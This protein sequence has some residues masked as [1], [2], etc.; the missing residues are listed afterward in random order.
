MRRVSA[1]FALALFVGCTS[2]AP[3]VP[4]LKRTIGDQTLAIRV[5]GMESSRAEAPA[6]AP[7]VVPGEYDCI[8]VGG[9]LSG[10]TTAWYLRD[11]KILVLERKDTAGGLSFQGTTPEGIVFGRG[12][13]YYAPPEK[14]SLRVYKDLGLPDLETT[15][16]PEPIDSYWYRGELLRDVWAEESL[17]K[18]PEGFRKF[19][20][21]LEE[22]SKNGRIPV[23]PF[24]SAGDLS[25]DK[26]S[27]AD[28][29]KPF[30]PE[31]RDFLDSYCKSALGAH[32][33]C[34]SAA[35]FCNFY[36]SEITVRHA[37]PGGTGGAGEHLVKKLNAHNPKILRTGATV[38]KVRNVANG[39]EVVYHQNGHNYL[40]RAK[41]AVMA[42]PLNITSWLVEGYPADRMELVKQLKF[43]DYVI[44]TVFTSRELFTA[45]YDTWF[46]KRS[47]TDLIV[48]RWVETHG[49]TK[50]RKPG[51]GILSI[52]QPLAPHRKPPGMKPDDIADLAAGAVKELY[53]MIP[54]LAKE[55]DLRIE[56]YRWP[57]SIHVVP[58]GYFTTWVPKLKAPVVR[59]HFAGSN[60]GTPSF[61]EALY[62]GWAAADEVR[63]LLSF[64]PVRRVEARA[65]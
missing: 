19:K 4:A 50:P 60:L 29:I 27:A 20:E 8:I 61:E 34:L 54:D 56:S 31:V 46:A 57:G 53:D 17:K 24:E 42:T 43:S 7:E 6:N 52:Y 63:K 39:V 45:G 15:E 33:E 13:A 12:A 58:P 1:L 11:R 37:W 2:S 35:A 48:G 18:L 25:L 16:I 55:K 32:P 21:Q 64:A 47:F 10:L 5:L 59:I 65:A 3:T 26:I 51:P 14:D 23:Q 9:G 40:V 62:R 38:T 28:Y 49:F 22:D 36:I 41:C 30:G 44:H